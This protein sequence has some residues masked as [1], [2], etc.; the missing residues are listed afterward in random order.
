LWPLDPVQQ[1][2]VCPVLWAPGPDT[3][4]PEGSHQSGAEGQNPLPRPAAHA[5]GDAAQGMVGLLGCQRILLGHVE[6]LANQHSQV[7][8]GRAALNPFIPQPVLILEVAATQVQDVALGL[9]EPHEIHTCPL[10]KL[11]QVPLDD[12]PSLRRVHCKHLIAF[13]A[14]LVAKHCIPRP[15]VHH[16]CSAG[17]TRLVCLG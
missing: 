7:L 2:H 3:G 12:I 9:V 8:L 14:S 1:V 10:L 4:L 11:V 13:G 15:A 6:L 16:R 5:A 17:F